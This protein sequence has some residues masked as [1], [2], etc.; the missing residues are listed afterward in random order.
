[1][2]YKIGALVLLIAV[3]AIAAINTTYDAANIYT[4]DKNKVEFSGVGVGAIVP[5][6]SV[7]YAIDFPLTSDMFLT[8]AKMMATGAC[9]DDRIKVQVV[10]G[11]TVV[12]QFIDWWSMDMDTQ[13]PIPSKIP[14]S[15]PVLGAGKLRALY[16]NTCTVPVKVR[17]NYHLY[18]I[19]E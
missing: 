19:L 3:T 14:A 9:G 5:E 1:M 7:D 4:L 13:L 11:N 18:K 17:V 12:K 10:F 16:T 2:K 6:N 8:G 15:H